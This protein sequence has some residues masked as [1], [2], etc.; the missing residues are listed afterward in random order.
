MESSIKIK[1]NKKFVGSLLSYQIILDGEATGYINNNKSISIMVNPGHHFLKLK[2]HPSSSPQ[3]D[4]D[5]N[6]GEEIRFECGPN[7][8]VLA[9][10]LLW[11][12]ASDKGI[13]DW[14]LLKRC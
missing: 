6:P 10:R 5:I 7:P 12:W 2:I 9:Y 13:D 8:S 11:P 3:I 14:I 4:F 1:R